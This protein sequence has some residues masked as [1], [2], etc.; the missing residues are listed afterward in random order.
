MVTVP[1][2]PLAVDLDG[3]LVRTDTLWETLF[4]LLRNQ[5]FALIAALFSL[6]HGRAA[7]KARLVTL[8]LGCSISHRKATN[9]SCSFHGRSQGTPPACE[10][11]GPEVR[12]DPPL[13]I[14]GAHRCHR[15]ADD[16][17]G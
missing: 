2:P 4:A 17:G 7:F 14:D 12:V 8:A 11:G 6:R 3:S 9:C 13:D 1:T 15:L 10:H 16:R 5:P